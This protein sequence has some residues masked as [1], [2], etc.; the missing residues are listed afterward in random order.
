MKAFIG[1]LTRSSS[2]ALDTFSPGVWAESGEDAK[3]GKW[4]VCLLQ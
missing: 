3:S 1:R 4:A 2:L